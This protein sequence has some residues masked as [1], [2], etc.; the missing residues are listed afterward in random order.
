MSAKR[1]TV[2]I[3][4]VLLAVVAFYVVVRYS[5]YAE[6]LASSGE[7]KVGKVAWMTCDPVRPF[8]IEDPDPR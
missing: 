7:H 5:A 8:W 6:C 3:V 2:V 4:C 1:F